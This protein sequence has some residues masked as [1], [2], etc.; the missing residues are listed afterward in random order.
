MARKNTDTD[1]LIDMPPPKSRAGKR[2][3]PLKDTFVDDDDPLDD[4]Q[5]PPEPIPF[6]SDEVTRVEQLMAARRTPPKKDIHT[7]P[8]PAELPEH[9]KVYWDELVASFPH[10]HFTRGDIVTMK[11]YCRCAHDIDRCNI[12]IEKEGDIIHGSRGPIAN[13]RVKVRGSSESTLLTILT[14]FRNQPASRANSENFQG[15]QGKKVEAD[16]ADRTIEADEDDLLGGRKDPSMSRAATY[17]N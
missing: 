8:Y 5:G 11:L 9:H 17:V 2:R 13:P 6:T 15:R 1:D 3:P 12:M 16:H 10:D 7:I 4:G 14:K